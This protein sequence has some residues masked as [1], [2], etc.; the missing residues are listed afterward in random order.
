M[1]QK[2][3]ILEIMISIRSLIDLFCFVLFMLMTP[4]NP[5]LLILRKDNQGMV[6]CSCDLW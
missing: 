1:K 5:N 2:Y 3:N 6:F 4:V